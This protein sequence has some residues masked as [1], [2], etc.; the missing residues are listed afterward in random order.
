[1]TKRAKILEP[2]QLE[3]VLK[4]AR[5]ESKV[6]ESAELRILLSFLAG[7]RACEIAGIRV[8]DMTDA[9]GYPSR[10]ISVSKGLGKG[11]KARDI[12]MHPLI[13]RSL[14][15]FVR[16]YPEA[17]FVCVNRRSQSEPL[18][19]LTTNALTIW[20][21]KLYKNVRLSGCSSHSGRRTFAT[22]LARDCGRHNASLREVQR[23][24]GHER[25]ETTEAYLEV[26]DN[27]VSM[28]SAL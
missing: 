8:S 1:M 9:L 24:L 13:R 4:S 15:Q 2:H 23:L 11:G 17:E 25:L 16:R 20:F 27:L 21:Y 14:E 7:L 12:P 6:P 26:S 5:E 28:V 18:Y 3:P 10:T 22:R 19:R